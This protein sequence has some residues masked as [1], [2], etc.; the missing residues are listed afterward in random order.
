[1]VVA[2]PL[3]YIFRSDKIDAATEDKA[4]IAADKGT[5]KEETKYW[6]KLL[7]AFTQPA[8]ILLFFA[9]A[10]RHTGTGTFIND[11]THNMTSS[12]K[13]RFHL[14]IQKGKVMYPLNDTMFLK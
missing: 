5:P 9:A 4:I 2:S 6:R 12:N 3:P 10:M 11:V 14:A 1:M 13:I 8:M 7:K